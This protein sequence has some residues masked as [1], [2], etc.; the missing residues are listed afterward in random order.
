MAVAADFRRKRAEEVA[1][2][3]QASID[4]QKSPEALKA[5]DLFAKAFDVWR[6]AYKS[7]LT[8]PTLKI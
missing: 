4:V 3:L 8:S 2:S 7:T 1:K 5:A 6:K